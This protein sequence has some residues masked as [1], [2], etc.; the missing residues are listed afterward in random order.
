MQYS[1]QRLASIVMSCSLFLTCVAV[2]SANAGGSHSPSKE[3][4]GNDKNITIK[5]ILDEPAGCENHDVTVQGI[6]KGWSGKCASSTMLTRSDWI[7]EDE[8]G[9]I[10]VTGLLPTG[11]SAD[12]PQGERVVVQGKVVLGTT[13]KPVIKA[14]KLTPVPK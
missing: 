14:D 8:T 3:I 7:L 5:Q 10:Y 12:K 13:G 4:A 6:Y 9:C 11:F 2:Q 1:L